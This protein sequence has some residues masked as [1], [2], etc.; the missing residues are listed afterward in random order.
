MAAANWSR[1]RLE[2]LAAINPFADQLRPVRHSK[3]VELSHEFA[4][5]LVPNGHRIKLK[6]QRPRHS[7]YYVFNFS[8][9]AQSRSRTVPRPC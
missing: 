8:A 6:R 5:R 2:E 4:N 3:G 9:V 7:L 1:V